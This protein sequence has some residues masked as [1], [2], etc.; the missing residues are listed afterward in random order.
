M[1]GIHAVP[2]LTLTPPM[3]TRLGRTFTFMFAYSIFNDQCM[4]LSTYKGG[5]GL[6]AESASS[7]QAIIYYT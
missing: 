5:A 3:Q 2:T 7:V 4:L 1:F 6:T